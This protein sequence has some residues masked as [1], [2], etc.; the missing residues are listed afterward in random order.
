MQI[1]FSPIRRDDQLTLEKSGDVL[2]INGEAF[3]FAPLPEGATL[4][5][6]AVACD[7]LL[8]DVERHDGE[9][10]LTLC[11]PHGSSAPG[12]T[13]FPKPVRVTGDGPITVP[14][15]GTAPSKA[16]KETA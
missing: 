6:A 13:L 14:L 16:A 1:T 3:D 2:I 8:S 12:E 9:V 11:L 4:P 7:W 10:H 5:Q 15:Y